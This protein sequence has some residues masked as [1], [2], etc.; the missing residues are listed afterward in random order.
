VISGGNNVFDQIEFGGSLNGSTAQSLFTLPAGSNFQ[1]NS[2]GD[3]GRVDKNGGGSPNNSGVTF[4]WRSQIVAN[5][6]SI[7][8]TTNGPGNAG[9]GLTFEIEKPVIVPE[10][11]RAVLLSLGLLSLLTR[12]QK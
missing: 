2:F 11:S 1:D 10:P 3:I 9:I 4:D 12:R 7:L 8:Y 6:G 5:S